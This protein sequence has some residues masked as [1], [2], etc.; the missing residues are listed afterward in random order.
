MTP[1]FVGKHCL[2]AA[3]AAAC[4]SKSQKQIIGA[5]RGQ[6]LYYNDPQELID[7]HCLKAKNTHRNYAVRIGYTDEKFNENHRITVSWQGIDQI[8]IV[9]CIN[10]N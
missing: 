8:D 9:L 10:S 1:T 4:L 5:M 6:H 3:A 2:T 7:K